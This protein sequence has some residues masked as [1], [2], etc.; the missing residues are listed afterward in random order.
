MNC[1]ND[2]SPRLCFNLGYMAELPELDSIPTE[3]V[4]REHRVYLDNVELLMVEGDLWENVT[5]V[6]T[7]IG[8]AF[9]TLWMRHV[10][11]IMIL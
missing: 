9:L 6:A 3:A 8:S 4:R 1:A 10:K 11:F 5:S 2:R 7:V